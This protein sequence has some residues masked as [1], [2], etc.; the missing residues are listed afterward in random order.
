MGTG[1]GLLFNQLSP[2]AFA[3]ISWRY[4]AVFVACDVVAA[5]CFFVF[6]P[7]TKGK[8]L[9]EMAVIFGDDLAI[10]EY[11]QPTNDDRL[12]VD[13]KRPSDGT[14]HAELLSIKQV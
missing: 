8:T 1:V 10:T 7:E 2:K 14:E 4:Y 13:S 5:F 11:L 9:E 6:Y 12:I 3:A